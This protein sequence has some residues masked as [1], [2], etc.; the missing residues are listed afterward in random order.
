MLTY[1]IVWLLERVLRLIL[2]SRWSKICCFLIITLFT[3]T[4]GFSQPQRFYNWYFGNRAG[5]NF[6]SGAPVALTNGQIVTTEGCASISDATGNLLFYTDGVS[7]WNR[8]H[9]VMPNGSG[10]FGHASSTQSA[11]IVQQP[12]NANLYYIFTTTADAGPSG[13]CYSVVDMTLSAGLGNVTAAKNVLIRTPSCEKLTAI[14]HCNNKDIWIVTHDWNSNAYRTWLLSNTGL[15]ATPVVSA[16]GSVINGINQS[17]YGQMKANPDGNR[18]LVA[19]YGFTGGGINRF[20]LSDFNNSTGVVS[21]T[22]VLANESGAYGCEFSPDGRL[23]YGGTNQ[24]RL[25]QWNLCAGTNAAISA[26][27]FVIGNLGP[28]I[29]S[30]QLGPDNK[31][32]VSRNAQFLSVINNPNVIGAGCGFANGSISLSARDSRMGLPNMASLY[33][34]PQIPPFTYAA[35]CLTVG[36]TAPTAVSASSSCSTSPTGIQSVNWNFGDVAS[37]ANNISTVLNPSH[38]FS[39]IGNYS[40]RLILNMGC[41]YDTLT[42]NL[43]ISGF[44]TSTSFTAASCGINNG[45]ATVTPAVAGSYTYLWSNGATTATASN[46]AAGIYTV[47]VTSTTGCTSNATVT[48]PSSGSVTVTATPTAASCFGTNTGSATAVGAGGT[49]PYTYLWSNG[50]TGNTATGLAAGNY[51]LTTTSANGCTATASFTITQPTQ[52]AASTSFTPT[53]CSGTGGTAAVTASGGTAPY[54][55]LWSNGA[56][57]STISNLSAGTFTVVVTDTRGCTIN[58]SATVTQP[59]AVALTTSNTSATCGNSNGTATVVASSA[60]AP[61]TYS[62]NT[63]PVQT[64]AVANNLPT[65]TYTVTVGAANGCNATANVTITSSGAISVLVTPTPVTCFG[66]ATGAATASATGGTAPY[67]YSWSNGNT[68]VSATNLIAAAY[69]VTATSANGCTATQNFTITQPAQLAGA[70][71]NTAAL[72]SGGGGSATASPTGGTSPYTYAWNNGATTQTINSLNA[73]NYSVTITDANGCSISR[74]TTITQPVGITLTTSFTATTCG[75]SNGTATVTA[76]GGTAPY[77]YSW[78]TIPAQT[79]ATATGLAGGNYTVNVTSSNGCVAPATVIVTTGGSVT[80]GVVATNA[81]CF[82]TST[83]SAI[84]TGNGGAAPYTYLWSNGNTG[85][86]ATGL[87]AGNYSVTTTDATGCTAVQSFTVNQPNALTATTTIAPFTCNATTGAASVTV[88]GGTIPYAYLWSNGAT[89]AAVTGLANGNYSVTITDFNGCT[90]TRNVS[91]NVPIALTGSI[92]ATNI[93]CNGVSNGSLSASVSGGTAPYAYLWS[94]GATTATISNLNTGNYTLVITDAN[95]CA[96]NRSSSITSPTALLATTS[97]L[98]ASCLPNS[99]GA[100]V[101]VSGG[102]SP[103]SYLWSSGATTANATGLSNGNYTVTTTDALGCS[104]VSNVTINQPAPILVSIAGTNVSCNGGA[105]GAATATV[106]GGTLPYTYNWTNSSTSASITALVS[107]NYTVTVSDAAGCSANSSILITQPAGIQLTTSFTPAI[108]GAANG[109]VGVTVSS[110]AGPFTYSWNTIPVQTTATALNLPSGAY[111]VTVTNAAGCSNT[112]SVVIPN[113]GGLSVSANVSSNVSCFGLND[114]SAVAI[115]NGGAT[116]YTYLWSNGNT[117]STASNLI[118]GTYTVTVTDNIGCSSGQTVTITEPVQLNATT[119]QTAIVCFG[120]NNGTATVVASGGEAPYTYSWSNGSTAATITGLSSGNYNVIVNDINNCTVSRNVTIVS[121][122]Q[123]MVTQNFTTVT[124]FGGNNGSVNLSVSGGN[125]PYTCLW[126]GGATGLS[127]T[128]L[129]A[130]NYTY[131]ITDAAGCVENGSVTISQPTQIQVSEN[132]TNLNCNALSDGSIDITIIGGLPNYQVVWSNGATTEDISGLSAGSYTATITDMAGCS[133]QNNAQITAPDSISYTYTVTGSAC[134]G[135]TGTLLF[136]ASGGTSPYEYSLDGLPYQT[137]PFFGS[138]TAGIH[139]LDIR[140]DNACVKSTMVTVPSPAG[141]G[142]QVNAITA[143]SCFGNTDGS[144]QATVTGGNAPY[145]FT[146]SSGESGITANALS[147][148]ANFVSVTDA[149]GC[150]ATQ[151]FSTLGASAINIQATVIDVLCYGASTGAIDL[152]VTGGAGN[153]VFDWNSNNQTNILSNVGAGNY[154]ITVYDDNNCSSTDT[155]QIN[156]PL[157]PII[158]QTF[159]TP[160]ACGSAGG[161]ISVQSIG[162]TAPYSYSWNTTPVETNATI[163][164]LSPGSYQVTVTDA[165][166]CSTNTTEV[167][168][169]YPG[170]VVVVDSVQHVNCYGGNDGNVFLNISGGIMPFTYQLGTGVQNTPPDSLVAGTYNLTVIDANGCSGTSNFVIQQPASFTAVATSQN[171]TCYGG[172]D[173]RV[174]LAVN[175][176]TQPYSYNWSNGIN[177]LANNNVLAG[178]YNCV[179]TDAAGCSVTANATV[180]QPSELVVDITITP[181]GCA[182]NNNGEIETQVSGGLS[183]YIYQWSTGAQSPVI[184]GLGAGEFIVNVIDQ[185]ACMVQQIAQLEAAVPFEVIIEGDTTICLGEQTIIKATGNGLHDDYSYTWNHGVT[186]SA[187]PANPAETTTYTVV[188][189][190][191]AD[192]ITIR[193]V[194]VIVNPQPTVIITT[195]DTSGCAPFCTKIRANSETATTFLWRTSDGFTSEGDLLTHCFD[196]PGI[197]TVQI[198]AED[199]QGCSTTLNWDATVNVFPNPE[200]AFVPDPPEASIENA[201]INF[202]NQSQGATQYNYHFGDPNQSTVLLPNTAFTYSDTGSFEV[203]LQVSNEYGCSDQTIQTIHIG[204]FVAF[205]VP[206]AFSPNEDGLNDVFLPKASGMAPDGFEM[207][208]YDRWGNVIFFSDSWDKG[209]DGTIDGKPVQLDLY[210]CKIKYFDRM[211]NG[212][213]HIGSVTITE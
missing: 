45:S 106:S 161:S 91:I 72:C 179:V 155:I 70:I 110:G 96:I 55:Y 172:T 31:V 137:S 1:K 67:T 209:W 47:A 20:E 63:T 200:A 35:N 158:L 122:L 2:K 109:S 111:T 75:A 100:S 169:D 27:M 46:L 182:G 99:G 196:L 77:T 104:I 79:T 156:Q 127:R 81:S 52:L 71:T 144:A 142:V 131:T 14:R 187:F 149:L 207:R 29:G 160:G 186:G 4:D 108:C 103:Y 148:G 195:D 163:G 138:L 157:Q 51:T 141:I 10:L 41:Y 115:A 132:I 135:S 60:P 32:Y 58:A 86:N 37:G 49:A 199:A 84:A 89:T 188:V 198:K 117:T 90:I 7:V 123:I 191:S 5:V 73:G 26:S 145:T 125:A 64:T 114:G 98:P 48:V 33:L 170:V 197:Y 15:N 184:S 22:F 203:T 167:L 153:Y 211:G 6:S 175:G 165:N 56:T 173:G 212:N 202:I 62:W 93:T 151:T 54:T 57:T 136:S 12:G 65:G 210:V 69:T 128:G 190:D 42:Q 133:V 126:N 94:N 194:T 9:V 185:N 74:N 130:G 116:P 82:G 204:G 40:V 129:V 162:G 53:N 68:G 192:C 95:G 118:A 178:D 119:T 39:A 8:N 147:A 208:I 150:T 177:T 159:V 102:T 174:F 30:L 43:T 134:N 78:N 140:D 112:A 61:Y 80:L 17:T 23:A 180:S 88:T 85:N 36:F 38:T 50:A 11:I 121:P 143:V 168:P 34:R 120:N 97:V 166:G 59:T 44:N 201:T 205:Y 206:K 189:K 101:T 124:C 193:N 183:P 181:P 105:N 154:Y 24:G 87:A 92:A 139:T 18:L 66:T 76:S 152:T 176:G 19:H 107:G 28:F 25:L 146:W 3:V 21:N 83:G 113:T 213:D 13:V 16:T 171:V 164:N